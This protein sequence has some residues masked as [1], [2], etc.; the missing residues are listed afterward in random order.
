[1]SRFDAYDSDYGYDEY[2]ALRSAGWKHAE[3]MALRGK[4][5]L[6]VLKEMEH[7]LLSLEQPRLISNYVALNGEVCA[8][9]AYLKFKGVDISQYDGYGCISGEEAAALG[10]SAGMQRT[11]AWTI[12][13]L[14]DEHC[15]QSTPEER[16]EYILNWVRKKISENPHNMEK[17]LSGT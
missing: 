9:G 14:N 3:A 12:A 6:R 10:A 2:D 4:R 13:N 16:Y 15:E 5:G 1:M 7:A 17:E 8:V 11:V